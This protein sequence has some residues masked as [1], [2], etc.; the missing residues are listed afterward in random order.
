LEH[1]A[2]RKQPLEARA[3]AFAREPTPANAPSL[4]SAG[5]SD[6]KLSRSA[7]RSMQSSSPSGLKPA[8][9]CQVQPRMISSLAAGSAVNPN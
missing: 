8:G 9:L 3:F 6:L 1:Q 7:K 2:Q 5:S 4:R